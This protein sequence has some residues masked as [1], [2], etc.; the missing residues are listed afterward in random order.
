MTARLEALL[1]EFIKL[2]HRSRQRERDNILHGKNLIL[3][4]V[5][6]LGILYE[7]HPDRI[8]FKE[9]VDELDVGAIKPTNRSTISQAIT[10]LMKDHGMVRK[11]IDVDGD[12]RQP[13]IE[14]TESGIALAKS[15]SD[16]D[17]SLIPKFID[18]MNLDEEKKEG[19][20]RIL[21]RGIANFQK[22]SNIIDREFDEQKPNVARVY[23]YMIGGTHNFAVD[24]EMAD[25]LL[26][27]DRSLRMTALASRAFLRRS[28]RFLAK[29]KGIKQ[30]VDIGSGLPTV[31]NTHEI[32]HEISPDAKVVYV[33]CDKDAIEAS[34]IILR[35]KKNARAICADLRKPEEILNAPEMDLI[36]FGSPV[37][38]VMVLVLQ[39]ITSD[40][41]A[42]QA[43]RTFY[44]R[45]AKGSCLVVAHPT[46]PDE[47]N[48]ELLDEIIRDY[49]RVTTVNLRSRDKVSRFFA[50]TELIP[51]GLVYTPQW[52]PEVFDPYAPEL[53]ASMIDEPFRSLVLAGVGEV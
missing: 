17:R 26:A 4:D 2:T 37:G 19:M 32:V 31:G 45:L 15:L 20:I 43:V 33:D 23:D 49:R 53:D 52:K 50:G 8:T 10:R 13:I 35:Q 6:I 12:Q 5:E 3:R 47:I 21:Q 30:F 18:A 25:V 34:K 39:F 46:K 48:S 22:L 14:L 40:D 24:R 51:P 11:V 1:R 36:D 7:H 38:I 42:H 27:K 29:E 41:E 28:V 16:V 44:Q 9:I